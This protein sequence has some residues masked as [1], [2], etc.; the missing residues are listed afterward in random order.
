MTTSMSVAVGDAL[1]DASEDDGIRS[2]I[3]TGTGRAFCAGADIKESLAGRPE[4]PA[5]AKSWGFGGYVSHFISKP[6]IA[7]VNGLALGLGMELMLASD[8][9]VAHEKA[10]F[11][12]PEVKIG[13]LAAGGGC[14]RIAQEVPRRTAMKLLFTGD[15]ISADEALQLGLINQ[16][17]RHDDNVLDAALELAASINRNAP[18]AVQAIKR[19]AYGAGGEPQP[20][21]NFWRVTRQEQAAILLTADATEGRRAFVEKRQPVLQ[22]R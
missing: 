15:S 11:S 7:A 12:L 1:E 21:E 4:L 6:T 16:V 20:D 8:L 9:A 14:F 2:V 3:L 18:L 17:V 22:S 5:R 19:I 13:T 10:A